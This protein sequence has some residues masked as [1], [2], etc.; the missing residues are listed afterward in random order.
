MSPLSVIMYNKTSDSE[1]FIKERDIQ[2]EVLG[3]ASHISPVLVTMPEWVASWQ[4]RPHS[5][6]K[7]RATRKKTGLL[8]YNNPF[9]TDQVPRRM[10]LIPS[11]A[12]PSRT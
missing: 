9:R 3:H 2:L 6:R 10:T 12:M 8:F 4:E 5:D 1:Y 11:K 7:L